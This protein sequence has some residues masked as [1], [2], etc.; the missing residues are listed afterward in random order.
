MR[1]F[2]P[3]TGSS[4]ESIFF[5]W[6]F[7]WVIYSSN[8]TYMKNK[9]IVIAGGS[10]FIGQAIACFFGKENEIIILGR[11]VKDHENNLYGA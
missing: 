4:S 6:L 7:S 9:K 8:C 5:A 10:G 11:S 2:F 3:V 1:E